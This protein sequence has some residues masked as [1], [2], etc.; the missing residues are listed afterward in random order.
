ML[1]ARV[2]S[3]PPI[4]VSGTEMQNHR[5]KRVKKSEMGIAPVLFLPHRMEFSTVKMIKTMPG[6][7]QEVNQATD[8]HPSVLCLIV[9]Q[10]R[11]PTYP[12]IIPRKR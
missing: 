5:A 9:L 4:R 2:P 8:F 3:K 6:K 1:A 12:A 10:T 11:T 7:K